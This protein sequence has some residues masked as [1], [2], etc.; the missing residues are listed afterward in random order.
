M[1]VREIKD[2]R[3]AEGLSLNNGEN[4]GPCCWVGKTGEEKLQVEKARVCFGLFE[5]RI[6]HPSGA[7]GG[8][9]AI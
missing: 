5:M 9:L 4:R 7:I 6:T 2:S 1:G 8:L 3:M